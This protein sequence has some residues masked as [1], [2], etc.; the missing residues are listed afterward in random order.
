M[1]SIE[2]GQ[3]S[4]VKV[5]VKYDIRLFNSMDIEIVIAV[6]REMARN[7]GF[8][9][10]QES[11]IATLA[12]E[13]ATNIIRYAKQGEIMIRIIQSLEKENQTGIELVASDHGPGIQNIHLA[14]Q[15]NYS[16][17]AGSLGMGLPTVCNYMDEFKIESVIGNG[18]H[19]IT[20]K[21]C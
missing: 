14:M 17:M 5:S 21:W 4:Q 3:L 20:R 10:N 13:L 1:F 11:M 8:G 7:A 12:S 15:E 16:T 6:T 2:K 18:T 9:K 19:I